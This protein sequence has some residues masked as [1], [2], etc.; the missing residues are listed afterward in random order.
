MNDRARAGEGHER[1]GVVVCEGRKMELKNGSKKGRFRGSGVWSMHVH[2]AK[3]TCC[4]GCCERVIL[5]SCCN[6]LAQMGFDFMPGPGKAGK[7]K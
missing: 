6:T 7:L 5:D 4:A 1:G 3:L 2:R